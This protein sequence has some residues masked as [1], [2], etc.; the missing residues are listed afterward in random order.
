MDAAAAALPPNEARQQFLDKLGSE[1]QD[2][3]KFFYLITFSRILPE[4]LAAAAGNLRDAASLTRQQIAAAVKNAFNNPLPP[5]GGGGRPRG[6]MQ[7]VVKKLVVFLEQHAD[8][9]KHYHVAV[10]LYVQSR[11]E[12][13]KRT[14]KVREK[15][16]AH[17]SCS[18]DGW[19]SVLRY[20]TEFSQKEGL[21]DKPHV[22]LAR[23]EVLDIFEESQEPYQAK[24]AVGRRQR[25]DAQAAQDGKT[26][27]FTKLDFTSIVLAKHLNSGAQVMRYVQDSGT[28]A[29]QLFVAQNQRFLNEYIED[30]HEWNRA[31]V[32]ADQEDLKDW[33]LLCTAAQADCKHGPQCRYNEVAQQILHHNRMN[34]QAG[35]LA[36]SI[37]KIINMGPCK[38]ARV[39]FLVGPTNTGK[40]TLVDSVD[41]LFHWQQVFHLP[42]DSDQ[43]FALRNWVKNKRF[44]YFDEY[45]PVEYA[46][47]KVITATTFKKAFGGQYF[48]I[49]CPKNWSD[50]NK[51]FKWNRGVIFTNKQDGLWDPVPGVGP[52]DIRHMQSRVEMFN[53]THQ[54]VRPGEVVRHSNTVP[55][56]RRCFAK[57]IVEAC[58]A[59]DAQQIVQV[60]PVLPVVDHGHVE[61]V[62][63]F[64]Q[65]AKIPERLRVAISAD[66]A[67]LGAA[68]VMELSQADWEDLPSWPLLKVFE[69]RRILSFVPP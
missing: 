51:D 28:T 17:F 15:L 40:S 2:A 14:L 48:E 69:R 38:E 58:A 32:A 50:G 66:V 20:G 68:D 46:R 25:K 59:F 1:T 24:A 34:F 5:V 29:M 61:G 64:L 57:W 47:S 6:R 21:D 10:Y 26:S 45:S 13:V 23:G 8:G 33:A 54:F 36:N 4:T 56:C 9:S 30:A 49:Q 22:W 18:H 3:H 7:N 12:A 63:L 43:K 44:V 60:G 35:H 67:A 53:F 19:W 52:E 41:D 42:A 11:W 62:S 39:P 65:R 31:R 37:R 27:K 55:E 16:A